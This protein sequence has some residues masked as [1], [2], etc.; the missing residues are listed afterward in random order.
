MSYGGII[1]ADTYMPTITTT[2]SL[3]VLLRSRGAVTVTD[4]ASHI[5]GEKIRGSWW[6]HPKGHEIFQ[7][8]RAS[9]RERV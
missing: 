8:G 3:V 1:A 9:C 6:G 5:A 7:I 4:F 2:K